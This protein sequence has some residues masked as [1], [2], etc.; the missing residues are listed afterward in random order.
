MLKPD[1]KNTEPCDLRGGIQSYCQ[2][3]FGD[4]QAVQGL[5][6]EMQKYR[7]RI[8]DIRTSDVHLESARANLTSYIGFINLVERRFPIATAIDGGEDVLGSSASTSGTTTRGVSVNLTWYDTFRPKIKT[9]KSSFALERAA[10][11]YNIAALEGSA[12]V[13]TN[14]NSEEGSRMATQ[15]FCKSAGVFA[16]LRDHVADELAGVAT[17]DLSQAALHLWCCTMIAQANTCVYEKGVKEYD[18]TSCWS[19]HKEKKMRSLLA[20]LAMRVAMDYASCLAAAKKLSGAIGPQFAEIFAAQ[21]KTF[22]A[23]ATFQ[24]AMAEKVESEK[25]MKGWGEC[26]ARFRYALGLCEEAK[27]SQYADV[28]ALRDAVFV[29][30]E[31]VRKDC[32][33]IYFPTEPAASALVPIVAIDVSKPTPVG[34]KAGVVLGGSSASLGDLVDE[35]AANHFA[36]AMSALLPRQVSVALQD[37]QMRQESVLFAMDDDW[38]QAR[39]EV[40]G[41]LNE[42]NLPFA[43]LETGDHGGKKIPDSVWMNLQEASGKG[44]LAALTASIEALHEYDKVVGTLLDDCFV[45]LEEEK[46]EDLECKARFGA[47]QWKR[48]SSETLQESFR[49][50]LLSYKTKLAEA[51]SA[52]ELLKGRFSNL[53]MNPNM[54]WIGKSRDQIENSLPAEQLSAQQLSASS[55]GSAGGLTSGEQSD[56]DSKF[57]PVREALRKLEAA[58]QSVAAKFEMAKQTIKAETGNVEAELLSAANSDLA[59]AGPACRK[60]VEG[61]IDAHS[62]LRE[63][64]ELVAGRA[65]LKKDAEQVVVL[66]QACLEASRAAPP[67]ERQQIIAALDNAATTLQTA[68]R[69]TADGINFYTRLGDFLRQCK[70]QISDFCMARSDEKAQLLDNIGQNAARGGGMPMGAAGMTPPPSSYGAANMKIHTPGSTQNMSMHTPGPTANQN[71]QHTP[72]PGQMFPGGNMMMQQPQQQ[73]HQM[74]G[75]PGQGYQ[76]LGTPGNQNQMHQMV[77]PGNPNQFAHGQPGGGNYM[78]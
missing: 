77:M 22:L 10:C 40:E 46:E 63:N 65:Q 59:N 1:V 18:R 19:H 61:K 50:N 20:K 31:K 6:T 68:L 69:D 12:A 72:G 54:Q 35:A 15:L 38:K 58:Q 25:T 52:N 9:Q 16:Y 71:M 43:V 60:I 7:D 17:H 67:S 2:R 5:A 76:Q 27:K 47:T 45:K 33:N 64:S 55:A 30:F 78:R 41:A 53:K 23:A 4:P 34:T 24:K 66:Y 28:N 62:A 49:G 75:G 36:P 44:G 42:H 13:N 51:R 11:I 74:M 26:L 14:R 56:R 57:A 21:E 70:Q 29:E 37:Y 73:H 8:R 39:V 48:E 3:H 32:E